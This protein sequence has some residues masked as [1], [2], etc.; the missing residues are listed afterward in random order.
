MVPIRD[1]IRLAADIYL[2][3]AEGVPED[4]PLPALLERT[5]YG[6]R[7]PER[8][9]R[10]RF[11]ARRGYAVVVQDC[12]GCFGSEGEL[13]F[14]KNEP[15]DG[16][17]T[18]EWIARQPWCDGKVG[19]YGTSYAAW[20]QLGLA[21]QNP[22]HLACMF[23]HMGGWNA[24]TS[25]V[26]QGGAMELRFMAWA[27][28]HSALNQNSALKREAW[29]SEALN[30]A[31]FRKW[32]E[33][34]PIRKG[35]T[36][37]ALVP[38]YERWLFDIFWNSDYGEFWKRPG[39][40]IEEFLEPIADVPTFLCGGWYDSY[41][42]ATLD[43][44][45]AL[46]KNKKGPIY[47]M[48]GP[49]THGTYTT[50]LSYAGD[51]DLGPAS[52]LESFDGLHLKWFDRWLKGKP[53]GIDR[54]PPVKIFVM[55]G[56]TGRKTREGKLDHGG[57]WR[58]E[59]VWPLPSTRYR[60]FYFHPG[61]LLSPQLPD[62]NGSHTSFR[63]D[64]SHPVPTVGGNFSSLDYLKPYPPGT[65]LELM[66]GF[67]RREP[68]TPNGGFDQR[69]DP[70]FFGS[71]P[72]YLPLSARPDVLVFQTPPLDEDTEITGPLRVKLWA[73]SSAVDTDFT[74]KL[75]DL[76]PPGPDYPEGCALN[77]SDSII[78]ARY[79]NS[80]DKAELMR[81]G[82]VCELTIILYPTSNLFKEGHRIR[83]DISS[84]NFPR[85]DVNSN[86]GEPLGQERRKVVAENTVY[87]DREHSSHIVLP[88]I[89]R[90]GA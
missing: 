75:I 41:A 32:L 78:R 56:A 90:N 29:V 85:F 37:L 65:K 14:L 34:M 74:A 52:A 39:F 45:M 82:Q 63:F 24:H 4:K 69:E 44:F 15:F 5:P 55:G 25:T 17:D 28:W 51:A 13:Y 46:S 3:A 42:R 12:R 8:A 10:A 49:W 53:T 43:T 72:P 22:P 31:D 83:V 38:A 54:E 27:F 71:R 76:Y 36:E 87:H 60:R 59:E 48:M 16:Y 33:R 30:N 21:T 81:P 9:G 40:G 50:E 26:R 19:T 47:V 80:R 6:K 73:S 20:T 70:K 35:Q 89:P 23:P 18:V 79:R 2:P 61:G 88:V 67:F 57:R 1:G 86:T 62:D 66:P 64:P 68:I 58:S 77:L 11:F 84:S 7:D